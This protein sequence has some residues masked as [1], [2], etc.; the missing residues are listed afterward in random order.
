MLRVGGSSLTLAFWMTKDGS[1]APLCRARIVTA[2]MNMDTRKK[3]ELS[4]EWRAKFAEY[5]IDESQFP[6]G[7]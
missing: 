1:D 6:S 5:A 4:D 7:R 2:A 3:V